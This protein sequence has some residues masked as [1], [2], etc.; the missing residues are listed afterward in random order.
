[1][2]VNSARQLFIDHAL[3]ADARGVG[4]TV[5]RPAPTGERC[6]TADRPWESLEINGYNSVMDDDGVLKLWYDAIAQDGSRW[7]CYATSQ[8][9][10]HWEKPSLGMVPFDGNKDT[11]IVFPPER[12]TH[13]PNCV[14]KDTNPA[15]RVEEK[16]KMAASLHPPGMAKGTY[17]AASADG[18]HWRLLKDSP[19]FRDS[20]T[21]NVC[22]FDNRIG[23]YVGYVRMWAPMRM[24][25]R[26]EFDDITNWGKEET[27]FSSDAE[28][29]Q[30][31]DPRFSPRT[32][33]LPVAQN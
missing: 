4:L 23:R 20:D 12:M 18:L 19:A 1:M 26:C 6:L 15:C 3:I 32:P 5:N 10:V 31:L 11:N 22:F 25:G 8:D 14:F 17:V 24:V 30:G 29:L 2:A 7:T 28:D 33:L 21:N 27:V 9:G 13:E 16:Y